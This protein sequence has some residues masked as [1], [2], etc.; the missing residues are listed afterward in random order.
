MSESAHNKNNEIIEA[1]MDGR[2]VKPYTIELS[3]KQEVEM[4][5][6]IRKDIY[7][8]SS[9][10]LTDKQVIESY[11][12][13]PQTQANLLFWAKQFDEKVHSNGGTLQQVTKKTHFK[14]IK[15]AIGVVQ[16][17]C[18]SG[19]AHSSE[20]NGAIKYKITMEEADKIRLLKIEV[21][22]IKKEK[23]SQIYNLSLQFDMKISSL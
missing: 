10:E 5:A 1:I 23:E 17:L 7:A 22:R 9:D 19:L 11:L 3:G 2:E 18:M 15:D 4:A 8:K 21:E 13:N 20:M 12:S 16:L 14:S 6:G